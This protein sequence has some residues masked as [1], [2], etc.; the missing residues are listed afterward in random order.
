MV[1][2]YVKH[3]CQVQVTASFSGKLLH[4]IVQHACFPLGRGACLSE[5]R[6]K[7]GY[8]D[9]GW[10][11]GQ[12]TFHGIQKRCDVGAARVG[13]GAPGVPDDAV[14]RQRCDAVVK[15]QPRG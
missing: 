5:P 11:S 15:Q 6:G 9:F 7:G 10:A 1:A 12:L 14:G 2:E 4:D 13:G 8:G 3:R